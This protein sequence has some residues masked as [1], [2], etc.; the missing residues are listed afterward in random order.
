[1]LTN[2][3]AVGRFFSKSSANL[4]GKTFESEG[5]RLERIEFVNSSGE[6]FYRIHLYTC[7]NS[8]LYESNKDEMYS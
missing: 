7:L 4:K 6:L 3:L 2:D 5:N 8:C 1:M